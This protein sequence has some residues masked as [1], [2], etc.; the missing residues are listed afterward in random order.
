MH[1]DTRRAAR[2]PMLRTMLCTCG[3]A[4]MLI[5]QGCS[6]DRKDKQ[7]Q[8]IIPAAERPAT[9]LRVHAEAF[10]IMAAADLPKALKIYGTPEANLK[11][12]SLAGDMWPAS[13][14][15][16][17]WSLFFS[18][19]LVN[20][21]RADQPVATVAFYHPWSDVMLLTSWTRNKDG[22]YR[23][24][25]ADV[26]LG[27][28]VRGA[29][30]RYSTIREWQTTNAYAPEAV[31]KIN[32]VTTKAFEAG[33]AGQGQNL[34]DKLDSRTR[35]AMPVAAA[36]PLAEFRL[37]LLPLFSGESEDG[38]AILTLWRE[39]RAG[40]ETGKTTQAGDVAA[41]IAL[42]HKLPPKVRDSIAPVG[43]L[44]T[45]NATLVIL[46]SRFN[47]DL[48]LAMQVSYDRKP[49]RIRQL[50]LLSFQS[51]YSAASGQEARP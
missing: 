2:K 35:A 31:G 49:A 29:K 8:P 36:I 32:T 18:T 25:S 37:E 50:T 43:Y 3:I 26:L 1:N 21:A 48:Y 6:G 30:P 7:G 39:V 19:A 28:V 12:A 42:L 41:T 27:A 11:F 22:S 46:A 17:G 40:I 14:G 20:V 33:F 34:L 5:V 51:F 10:R 23:I 38:A 4:M 15:A 44:D 13:D 24:G 16:Q 47:P 45:D 9:D